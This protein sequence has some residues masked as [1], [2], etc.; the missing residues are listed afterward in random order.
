VAIRKASEIKIGD[1][2]LDRY[3]QPLVVR[4]DSM[5]TRYRGKQDGWRIKVVGYPTIVVP[6]DPDVRIADDP[7]NAWNEYA[8]LHPLT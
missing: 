4:A 7:G 3:S 6:G 8:K 2:I 5:P 1:V